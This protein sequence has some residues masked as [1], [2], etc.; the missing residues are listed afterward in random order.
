MLA[1][2]KQYFKMLIIVTKSTQ[3]GNKFKNGVKT[4]KY[5]KTIFNLKAK[6]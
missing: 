4:S 3:E 6:R 1:Y 2:I 5:L